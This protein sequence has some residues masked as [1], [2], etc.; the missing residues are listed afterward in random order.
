MALL[1]K[2]IVVKTSTI[3]GSGQGLFSKAFI[4]KGAKVVEYKGRVSTWKEVRHNNG[5]NA[6]IYF[7]NRNHVIDASKAKTSFARYSNDAK[8]LTRIAGLANN[9]EYVE[10]GKRVFIIAKRDIQ[11]GEEIF[12][13]YGAEY[14]QTIRHNIR[15]EAQRKKEEQD[16]IRQ[17]EKRE[18]AKKKKL[19]QKL[20][21]RASRRAKAA[22]KKE[23]VAARV[24]ARK[25]SS[26]ARAAAKKEKIAARNAEKKEQKASKAAA[27]KA[28]T[29]AK[30]AKNR[31]AK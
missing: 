25:A 5:E 10:E 31:P 4:P 14:W 2:S 18:A 9:A 22:A 6:Y 17:K 20:Q 28:R 13:G 15:V 21:Q 30:T 3:P 23:K 27:K 24:A 8:G 29:I 19:D 11:P 16:K 7:M 12:V 1:E 26:A